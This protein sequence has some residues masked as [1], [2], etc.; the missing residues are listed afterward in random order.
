MINFFYSHVFPIRV[1][2]YASYE[3]KKFPLVGREDRCVCQQYGLT[4]W[5][6]LSKTQPK[7]IYKLKCL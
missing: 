3:A 5:T 2:D 1:R 6:K 4:S 7:S